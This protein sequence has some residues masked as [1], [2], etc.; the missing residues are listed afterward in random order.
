M[1]RSIHRRKTAR[2]FS[3]LEL[4]VAVTI[5]MLLLMGV[6]ALFVSSRAS[7]ETTEK[8]SRIQ[9]NGRFALDQIGNDIRSAGYQG[10]SRPVGSGTRRA[11]FG[12]NTLPTRTN[13]LWNFPIPVE[14][15]QGIGGTSFA[16]DLA[17]AMAPNLLPSPAPS[18][19]GDVLVLRIPLR[20]AVAMQLAANQTNASDPLQVEAADPMRPIGPAVITDCLARTYFQITGYAGNQVL[21][22]NSGNFDNAGNPTD[23]LIHPYL[24]GAEIVP[25]MTVMYYLAPRDAA[26]ANAVPQRLS[27][28][29]REGTNPSEELA[30]GI[31]RLEVRYGVDTTNDGRVD[32]YVDA[33]AIP[34][35]AAGTP[36][37]NTVYSVQVSLLARAPEAYGTDID[38]QQ[39]TLLMAGTG[40]VT[41]V[42]A[43]PFND[44][45][46]RKVFTATAALR[47]QIID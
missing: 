32:N 4:M 23:S 35:A 9:E 36:N 39:Y 31:E 20:D 1:T 29:R 6:V 33:D 8:L 34:G 44:R 10:C 12:L 13:V 30:E 17:A 28:Y 42:T 43:G 24:R 27:L 45:F 11:G 26:A 37:W 25:L 21:H 7:Y 2:G 38:A 15:F 18:G 14:G 41:R 5:S 40:G 3:L 46:Q 47:N 16:P 19:V 22:A